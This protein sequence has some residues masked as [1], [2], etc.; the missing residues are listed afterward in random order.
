MW[1]GISLLWLLGMDV[2]GRSFIKNRVAFSGFILSFLWQFFLFGFN[3]F[4]FVYSDNA[5]DSFLDEQTIFG[6]KIF[7][8]AT[9][10]PWSIW[11][12][13][14]ISLSLCSRISK[15]KLTYS[16]EGHVLIRRTNFCANSCWYEKPG[17]SICIC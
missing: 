5:K 4:L 13:Y 1:N 7:A 3:G 12:I 15:I 8:L 16:F 17:G 11:A 6:S 9:R 14:W 2:C 10:K